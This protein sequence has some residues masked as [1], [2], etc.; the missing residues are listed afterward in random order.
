MVRGEIKA[1]SEARGEDLF[2]NYFD[3]VYQFT[4][5]VRAWRYRPQG[6]TYELHTEDK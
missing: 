5:A 1:M 3:A 4:K 6:V 2:D